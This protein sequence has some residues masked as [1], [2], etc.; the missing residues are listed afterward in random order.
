MALRDDAPEGQERQNVET[1]LM[2]GVI[3][4]VV[5]FVIVLLWVVIHPVSSGPFMAPAA[6]A[7]PAGPTVIV[8]PTI[9][10]LPPP[11]SFVP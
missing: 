10:P 9:T 4:M 8:V 5:C 2:G 1:F 11:A 3:V 7:T 6:T